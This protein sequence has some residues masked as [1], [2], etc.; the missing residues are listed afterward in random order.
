MPKLILRLYVAGHSPNSL[1]A[2]AN[3][4]HVLRTDGAAE[5][6]IEIVD[7]LQEPRRALADGILIS[8][9]LVKVE[10]LPRRTLIGSLSDKGM[11]RR[12]LGLPEDR[13]Q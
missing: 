6:E 10:P 1:L 8:P 12:A 13:P 2:T 3:L 11:V 7:V 5:H 4:Q 9:T